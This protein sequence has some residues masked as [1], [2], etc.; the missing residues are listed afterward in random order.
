MQPDDLIRKRARK[1][2]D[3][4]DVPK[5]TLQESITLNEKIDALIDEVKKKDLLEYDIQI[6]EDARLHLKG[7]KGGTGDPGIDGVDGKD[8]VNGIDGK[9]GIDGLDGLNGKDGVDG[10]DGID[11]KDGKD[12]VLGDIKISDVKE[13]PETIATLQNR[14]QLLNQMVSNVANSAT[15]GGATTF[16]DLTDTPSSYSGQT[17]KNVRVNAGETGLEFF[18]A[19]GL[20]NPMTTLG[21]V[22]YGE[23][24]GTPTRLAGNTTTL[25]KVL[26]QT[27]DGSI[28]S[29]PSWEIIPTSG[30]L[31]YMFANTASDISTYY[32]AVSLST[33]SAGT[34]G[35]ITTAGV[36]TTPTLLGNFATEVG[37]PN[38]TV[39]PTGGYEVHYDTEKVAGSNNYYTY[40]EIYKRASGG[41]ETL[42]AT[43]DISTQTAVNTRVSITVTGYNPTTIPLLSSDRI[44]VKVYGVMLS[45]TA[46]IHLYFDDATSARVSFPTATVDATNFVP[47]TGATLNV[48][49][50]TKTITADNLSGTNTGD[51]AVNSLYSGLVS[52]ATHTGDATGATALTVVALN[53]TSLAGLATGLLKNTTGTGVPSIAVNS[54][55]PPM[56]ATVGGAVPTPP[57]NTTTFLR[58]DGTFATPVSS[59]TITTQDEGTPLSTTVTT[60]NFT[61]AGVTAS[62]AGATTT[63]NIP[64]G[65]GSF[66]VTN[67]EVD[68]GTVPIK[69]KRITV[70]DA[71]ITSASKIMVTPNGATATGRVGNDWEWDT[72]A[73]SAVPGTGSFILTGTASGRIVG[74]R[75][76]FYTYS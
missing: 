48:D 42:I 10:I 66:A 35:D 27:G 57:N 20:T 9:N 58:G 68:F 70:T 69:S 7:D 17:L 32:K 59:A 51:N 3:A 36:S 11:G 34:I 53:G 25:T 46:T 18:T 72:I 39:I 16:T 61:G 31:T 2:V 75:K 50:G 13:L 49:L 4:G 29:A 54:D 52:N 64:G 15:S 8:G 30:T 60:L 21:D 19:S 26:T 63:I 71:A 76:I 43:T 74:K 73:F 12:A 38:V 28:S 22:I 67:A 65:A 62:G 24:S 45:S 6:D 44:V 23:A 40:A 47:Y 1:I 33:Y 56:T 41:T 5:A 14:T 37:F 55:L